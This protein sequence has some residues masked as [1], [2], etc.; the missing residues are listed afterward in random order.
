ME[1][2]QLLQALLAA[3]LWPGLAGLAYAQAPAP[4]AQ[5][6]GYAWLKG[7][8]RRL[9]ERAYVPPDVALPPSLTGLDYTRFQSI[10]FKHDHG[11]WA[12]ANLPF[13][14]EYFHRGYSYRERVRIYEVVDGTAREIAYDPAAYDLSGARVD[15]ASLPADL[16]FAGFRVHFHTNFEGDVAAFLGASYFRAV[17]SDHRQFGLSA[18]GLAVDTGSERGEEFPRFTSFWF[19]RP[20]PGAQ[21]LTLYALL[22]SP[23]VA[24]AYR[25]DLAPGDTL[26]ADVDAAIYPRKSIEHMGVAPLT[27]MFLVGSAD[28]R[29]GGDWRP[30]VHDSDGLAMHTGA[31]E[32][33]WR[34]LSNPVGVHL[35]TYVD[36][37]PRGFGL[38]QR[39]RDFDH[40]QDDGVFYERRPSVWVVPKAAWGRGGVQLLELPAPNE[41]YDNIVVYWMPAK[42]PEPGQEALYSY[43]TYWG[44]RM[45]ATPPVARVVST[46][47]GLGGIVGHARTAFSWRFVIDFA[48]GGLATLGRDA[49]V[50][51]VISASRGTIEI[52]SARPLAS[53]EGYRAIFDIQPPDASIEPIDLRL[54]LKLDDQVLSETWLYQWVPPPAAER[55]RLLQVG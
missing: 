26:I 31:G 51:P 45:P 6:F 13:R 14:I 11:L 44:Q 36:Q 16:G 50:Q 28:R 46:R 54:Q 7:E 52:P 55:T 30:Q 15:G 49:R 27:S 41:T 9:A 19:E 37:D 1:R 20:A 32:W 38:M 3:P 21:V 47:A 35:Y 24:G 22:D 25:I 33:L 8:A 42:S 29:V 18:R 34:P 12:D 53:I 2:R 43:R 4:T 10:R 23:S 40:Y 5:P 48:G 17:G 39:D